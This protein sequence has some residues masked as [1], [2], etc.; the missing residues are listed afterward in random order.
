MVKDGQNI[1]KFSKE[2]ITL[3]ED[4][5]AYEGNAPEILHKVYTLYEY[6]VGEDRVFPVKNI[7]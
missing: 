3:G 4:V 6:Y 5:Y 1:S 7:M 2:A